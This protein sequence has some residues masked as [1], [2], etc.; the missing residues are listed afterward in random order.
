MNFMNLTTCKL[1][2][3]P[4]SIT[5]AQLEALLSKYTDKFEIANFY[6]SMFVGK[7]RVSFAVVDLPE[8]YIAAIVNNESL[9]KHYDFMYSGNGPANKEEECDDGGCGG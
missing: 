4:E 1:V 9:I 8:K 6:P 5:K 2:F 7:N 3:E